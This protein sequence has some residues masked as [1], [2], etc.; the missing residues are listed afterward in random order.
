M[1]DGELEGKF[2]PKGSLIMPNIWQM[3]HD[4]RNYTDPEAFLPE[5]FM[6]TH[7][8]ASKPVLDPASAVFG[9]GRRICPGRHFAEASAWLAIA[10][11]LAVFNLE[12]VSDENGKKIQPDGIFTSGL[13][14][15]PEKFDCRIVP[16][17]ENSVCL[18]E[19][20]VSAY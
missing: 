5:R 18:I 17:S 10:S 14:I 3:M 16:R 19:K 1:K 8:A 15:E 12:P 20:A 13:H 7:E 6:V 11:I 4:E 2:I 9:F